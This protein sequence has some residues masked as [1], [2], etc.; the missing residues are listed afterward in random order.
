MSSILAGAS[1][2]ERTEIFREALRLQEEEKRTGYLKSKGLVVGDAAG[3]YELIEGDGPRPMIELHTPDC[4]CER[5]RMSKYFFKGDVIEVGEGDRVPSPRFFRKSDEEAAEAV[6]LQVVARLRAVEAP[7]PTA[8]GALRRT[9]GEIVNAEGIVRV[10]L[11]KVQ[12]LKA[13]REKAA[14]RLE[15]AQKAVEDFFSGHSPEWRERVIAEAKRTD[16][17]TPPPDNT[18]L[19]RF[20]SRD[21][22]GPKMYRWNPKTMR[23]EEIE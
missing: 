22:D 16:R 11:E 20:A 5:L 13:E 9:D 1:R 18:P 6:T 8:E 2:Q 17:E 23:N 7:V 21:P 3:L 15:D 10:A 19:R 4:S 12:S 14:S